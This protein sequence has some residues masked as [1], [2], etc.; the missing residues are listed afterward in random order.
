[1]TATNT[2]PAELID[3][4][5]WVCWKSIVRDSGPTKV[6]FQTNG[7]PASTAD[8]ETWTT[9]ELA[10]ASVDRFDGLGFTFS[11]AD[12][13]IGIDLDACRDPQTGTLE[14]WA[15]EV[16]NRFASYAEVSPSQTG[17]K[18]FARTT[19]TW[20]HRNKI[21]LDGDGYN[22]KAPGIEV[23]QGGRFFTVTGLIV[24][25][26]T[27]V[28]CCDD[29]LEWLADR[30][31]M[32]RERTS[33]PEPRR[34]QHSTT[35]L[36]R[37]S[38]YLATLPPSISGQ[39]GS[40]A[41]FYAACRLVKG[42]ELTNSEAMQL[43]TYEFNPRCVPPWSERELQHKVEDARKT[44]G[45]SGYLLTDGKTASRQSWTSTD[46]SQPDLHLYELTEDSGRTDAANAVRFI[47]AN[48]RKLLH[49]PP[50]RKWLAWDG[51][52]WLD[53]SGVSVQ[54]R[55]KRY[56]E[57][58]WSQLGEIGRTC[59]RDDLGR[60]QWFIKRTNERAKIADFISL[61][62]SDERIVCQVE[63]LNANPLLLNCKNGTLDLSTGE[64]R[65]HDPA[66]RITQLAPVEYDATADCP[67][68]LETLALIFD[69]DQELI[70]YVQTL[71]GYSISGDIGEHILPICFGSGCNGKSTVWNTVVD[72]LGDYATLAN[73]SL[74]MGEADCHPTDKVS[75]YQ[76][77]FV[78]VSEPEQNS[79]LREARVKELT[80]DSTIT[81]RRMREDF[82]SFRRS[83]KFWIST[84]HL[85]RIDGTDEGIW[86]RVKLIPFSVDLRTKVKP[87]ADFPQMLVRD[88]G[89]GILA[90]LVRGWMKYQKFGFVEPSV[91]QD[92]TADYRI[93]SDALGDFLTENC[94]VERRAVVTAKAIFKAYQTWGGKE[95]QTNFGKAMAG[96]FRKERPKAGE[97][98][99]KTIY[100]GIGLK[101]DGETEKGETSENP[102]ENAN[103]HSWAQY[104][105]SSLEFG[106]S[107]GLTDKL[108]PTMPNL[109]SVVCN[110]GEKMVPAELK[111]G[112]LR[113][114]ECPKCGA[115]NPVK[116][117]E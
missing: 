81:A 4:N 69:G 43:L 107:M 38:K 24:G 44:N 104:S 84:N 71:L 90:W 35:V 65:P 58:L 106:N 18:L 73:E 21:K 57:G 27:E 87:V 100:H 76:K 92:A 99:N 15:I 49:V 93:D 70:E 60:V 88:E 75:L 62:A 89:A 78:P 91:V 97:Y 67:K 2:I 53:D 30:F 103:G 26:V 34:E 98:R 39:N 20:N 66:D 112:S 74:L 68:W 115:A 77:R 114:Y 36:E 40:D 64:L 11:K 108:C 61:A 41:L 102:G 52:R 79:K 1:V 59:D 96:R 17:V 19:Q 46:D 50:W 29:S 31:E 10:A 7:T 14:P 116:E 111:V 48:S 105:R 28:R 80:G 113:N 22:G 85:P 72:L 86:R 56:A 25:D 110:C 51:K 47:D 5:Q 101:K 9:F 16:V 32:R 45:E 8:P 6:P 3:S 63:E 12:D 54:Q 117:D 83:H 55:A 82:W 33:T 23:Y 42:F 94:V 109:Q 95:N 37:A 13:F